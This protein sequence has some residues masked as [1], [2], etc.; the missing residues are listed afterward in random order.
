MI[1][2]RDVCLVFTFVSSHIVLILTS[3]YH[4][5]LQLVNA[6]V[7]FLTRAFCNVLYVRVGK[8]LFACGVRSA[9]ERSFEDRRLADGNVHCRQGHL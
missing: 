3:K 9:R 1:R 8:S 5:V 2:H 7:S 4:I 6:A